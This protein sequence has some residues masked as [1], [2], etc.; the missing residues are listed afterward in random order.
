[1]V[2]RKTD[3]WLYF[4]VLPAG[5]SNQ[6][7][8]NVRC[9]FCKSVHA[10]NATRM[11]SHLQQCTYVPH[12]IKLKFNILTPKSKG[13]HSKF[14]FETSMKKIT[15]AKLDND[16]T[17]AACT[18]STVS[19]AS[20]SASDNIHVETPVCTKI[21]RIQ[22]FCDRMTH[23]QNNELNILLAR[24]IYTSSAPHSITE[25]E[26]W[27]LFFK[28][29][30]P[31]YTLP[32]RYMLSNRLLTEEYERVEVQVND[33][34]KQADNLSLQCDGWSNL[35]NES[36]INFIVTTPEPLFV[37]SVLTKAEK[38][39]AEY[40]TKLMVE[41]LE[42]YGP[43][44]FF[45]IVTD[46]AKNMRKA[47]RQC[48]EMYPH[49]VSYGC[50]AHTLHL[51]CSDILKLSSI[52]THLSHIIHIV[53]TI[54]QCQVLRAQFTEIRNEMKCGVSLSLP[55]KTRWGSHVKCL[56]DLTKCKSVLQRLAISPD[57]TIQDR[58]RSAKANLLDEGF[59]INSSA[60][61]E[62]LKP[63]TEAIT[64]LEG[65]SSSIHLTISS[66]HSNTTGNGNSDDDFNFA[67]FA[68][69]DDEIDQRME[70]R[71]QRPARIL[72]QS[73][74]NILENVLMKS[75]KGTEQPQKKTEVEKDTSDAENK[76]AVL[77]LPEI[78]K[79][80]QGSLEEQTIET[81][82]F[83]NKKVSSCLRKRKL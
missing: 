38:H 36:V 62:L 79:I 17:D 58:I 52:E 70:T 30:R 59:W 68:M 15:S 72:R 53:K 4:E 37:K 8:I 26:D 57:K 66:W 65:D 50:L 51:L 1:M 69:T 42:E 41:V 5:S 80:T 56:Q 43:K 60:L 49:L 81:S 54:N 31:S 34:I 33:K 11:K 77:D 48:E 10:K 64:R 2:K 47:V 45:A 83:Y 20:T 29:I 6:K 28:K 23:E 25:N 76:D 78:K 46:N 21:N 3:I 18:S 67:D 7:T 12:M 39:T 9:K 35:R 63:I 61:V 14:P 22:S 82:T 24:A 40:I 74:V 71:E 32:S 44:K 13:N 75:G 27:K 55:V 16:N 19:T 73:K